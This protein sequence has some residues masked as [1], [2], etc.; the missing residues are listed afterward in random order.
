MEYNRYST[1]WFQQIS[2]NRFDKQNVI[3][4]RRTVLTMPET[5]EL[6]F[7]IMYKERSKEM[8]FLRYQPTMKALN[9]IIILAKMNKWEKHVDLI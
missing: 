7:N 5:H 8:L 9:C 3:E 6:D 1:Y 4:Y 2:L